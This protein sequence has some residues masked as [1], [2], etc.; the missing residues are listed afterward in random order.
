[1][2]EN[3]Y[4]KMKN[5]FENIVTHSRFLNGFA[6][7]FARELFNKLGS[8]KEP[9]KAPYLA[10]FKYNIGLDGQEQNTQAVRKLGFSIIIHNVKPDDYEV[11]YEAI[12]QAEKFALKVLSRMFYE[13]KKP[14]HFLWNSIIKES[15]QIVP[16]DIEKIGFGV[17]VSFN[18][19]NK[20]SMKVNPE[21]WD[22][23]EIVC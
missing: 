20:Q 5:Y 22:D 19:K 7:F 11:Q 18:I 15:I 8:K 17:E 6:G 12:D 10:L 9:L 14:N 3:G 13:N 23:I 4:L 1:M 21:D 16:L 2:E